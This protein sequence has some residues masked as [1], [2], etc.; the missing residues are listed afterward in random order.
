MLQNEYSIAKIDFDIAS[1]NLAKMGNVCNIYQF[2]HTNT[3]Y[4]NVEPRKVIARFVRRK[5][6]LEHLA[7]GLDMPRLQRR[8]HRHEVGVR[9][10][11]L[12]FATQGCTASI[13]QT[14]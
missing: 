7:G 6:H 8:D 2:T 9:R 1:Q 10:G 3:S 14:L 4:D 13:G 5:R 12:R 11:G